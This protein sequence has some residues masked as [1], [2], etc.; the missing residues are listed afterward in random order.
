MREHL[1]TVEQSAILYAP[2]VFMLEQEYCIIFLTATQGIGW[3]EIEGKEYHVA[4]VGGLVP[5]H[6][7]VHKVFVPMEDLNKAKAYSVHF[8]AMPNR[9]PYFPKS[10]PIVSAQYAFE[11]LEGKE[12]IHAYHLCDTH[13]HIGAPTKA[14]SYFGEDTDLILMNGDIPDHSGSVEMIRKVHELCAKT[15]KGSRPIVFARGNHDTRGAASIDFLSH[16]PNRNGDTFYTV[17]S[18]DLW[19]LV[20]DCGEDKSDGNVE[21]GGTIAFTPFRQRELAFLQKINENAKKEYLAEGVKHRVAICHIPLYCDWNLFAKDIYEKWLAELN[22]MGLE[23][24]L[25]GHTH[26]TEYVAPGKETGFGQTNFPILVGG[27]MTREG[28]RGTALTFSKDGLH[29]AFTDQ[30][31]NVVAEGKITL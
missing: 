29:Y 21:Y 18:G 9:A 27:T 24:M 1:L 17:R 15:A 4:D 2:A 10:M 11:G 13:S 3:V 14:A 16:T 22:Q 23:V 26:T 30:D 12:S 19:M 8:A 31:H 25:C 7:C 6:R 28:Y 5:S 20:L